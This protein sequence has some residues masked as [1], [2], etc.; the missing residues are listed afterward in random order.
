MPGLFEV[1]VVVLFA[2]I[3][4]GRLVSER[5]NRHLSMEQKAALMDAFSGQRRWS[6]VPL[7]VALIGYVVGLRLVHPTQQVF[8]LAGFLA[9]LG[10]Y[11]AV[12]AVLTLRR[13]VALELPDAYRS[14]YMLGRVIF[15]CGL[16]VFAGL[17]LKRQLS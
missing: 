15:Y 4:G 8:L 13:M 12:T 2:G 7:V 11:L 16:I 5:A 10:L 6:M 3:V 17:L 9:A 1:G 14:Q